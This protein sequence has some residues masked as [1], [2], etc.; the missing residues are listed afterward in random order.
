VPTRITRGDDRHEHGDCAG[1]DSPQRH[2]PVGRFAALEAAITDEAEDQADGP[3]DRGDP[4][5]E[6]EDD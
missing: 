2:R 5:A 1:D 3:K 6:G 4:E